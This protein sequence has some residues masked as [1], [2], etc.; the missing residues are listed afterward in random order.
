MKNNRHGLLDNLQALSILLFPVIFLIYWMYSAYKSGAPII[1]PL[2]ALPVLFN[3]LVLFVKAVS[4]MLKSRNTY[5]YD[6]DRI[7]ENRNNYFGREDIWDDKKVTVKNKKTGSSII[8]LLFKVYFLIII[9]RSVALSYLETE[10]YFDI[11]FLIIFAA[12][13]IKSVISDLKSMFGAKQ[14]EQ[15]FYQ[16]SYPKTDTRYFTE[17]DWDNREYLKKD[18]TFY[19]PYC[20]RKLEESFDYCP[21]CGNK[22][23]K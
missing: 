18:I 2:L 23:H 14:E 17:K 22:L 11:L 9:C 3:F 12:A 21:H 15:D 8:G 13:M 5:Q 19:C 7:Y 16:D 10:K 6:T 20:D 4:G 1:V